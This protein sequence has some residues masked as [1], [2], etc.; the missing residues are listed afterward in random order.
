VVSIPLAYFGGV[1]SASRRRILV[2]GSNLL[3]VITQVKTVMC[4]QTGK[5]MK[6]VFRVT[7]IVPGNDFSET[8]L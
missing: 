5:L 1:G 8:A 2:K 4:D 7:Q 3:D 6:G